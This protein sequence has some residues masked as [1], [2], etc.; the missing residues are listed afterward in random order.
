ELRTLTMDVVF[1]ISRYYSQKS[2]VTYL[3]EI[4][5][6]LKSLGG[7]GHLNDIYRVMKERGKL[8]SILTNPA[9]ERQ[10]SHEL[11]V[12]STDTQSYV[13][14]NDDLFYS[15]EGIGSGVWGLRNYQPDQEEQWWPTEEEYSPG[16]TT[17]DWLALL[18]D[19]KVFN[20]TALIIVK[21]FKNYGGAGTCAQLATKYGRDPSFYR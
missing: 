19:P 4:T 2:K 18:N 20:G 3:S 12:H 10:V 6:A 15:V 16:L 8:Q 13:E 17:E 5:E 14:G 1:Y 7:R 9:W 21:C 11:Q